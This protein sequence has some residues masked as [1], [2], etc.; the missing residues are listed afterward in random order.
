MDIK[1]TTKMPCLSLSVLV[2]TLLISAFSGCVAVYAA[3]SGNTASLK[4]RMGSLGTLARTDDEI[5]AAY[6]SAEGIIADRDAAYE[7]EHAGTNYKTN[8][9]TKKDLK[10]MACVIY[11]EATSMTYEAKLAVGN[12]ILNRTRNNDPNAWGHVSTIREVI[13][14]NKWG[15]QFAVTVGK[16]SAMDKAMSLYK[17]MDTDKYAQWQID[18]MKLAIKAA[19]AVLAGEK[20]I[21][22]NFYYFNGKVDAS[23]EKCRKNGS[24]FA[25]MGMEDPDNHYRHIYF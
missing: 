5:P 24:R 10:Y 14:D 3:D 23:I 25:V 11:C 12:V 20:A 6:D 9:F 2:L 1:N 8:G 15:T 21:P 7:A 18:E 19:K 17:S 16:P 4:A 22:D 13:Y